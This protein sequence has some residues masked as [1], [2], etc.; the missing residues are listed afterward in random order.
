MVD[1]VLLEAE[2]AAEAGT[3][4]PAATIKVLCALTRAVADVADAIRNSRGNR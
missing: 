4:T 3:D 1:A 2:E